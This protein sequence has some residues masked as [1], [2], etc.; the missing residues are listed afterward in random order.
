MV[1]CRFEINITNLKYIRF[2]FLQKQLEICLRLKKKK[3]KRGGLTTDR[4]AFGQARFFLIA[5]LINFNKLNVF[6]NRMTQT[7]NRTYRMRY[8]SGI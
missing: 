4:P 6:E 8:L 5:L 3:A 2:F 7:G 1:D